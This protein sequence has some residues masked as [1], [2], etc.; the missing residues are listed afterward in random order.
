MTRHGAHQRRRSSWVDPAPGI[1]LYWFTAARPRWVV[2][3][4]EVGEVSFLDSSPIYV[5]P[6]T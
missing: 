1:W 5:V 4:S 3:G 2:R 6:S